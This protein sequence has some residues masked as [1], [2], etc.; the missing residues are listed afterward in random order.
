MSKKLSIRILLAAVIIYAPLIFCHP[1]CP[2]GPAGEGQII[3]HRGA[4]A[5]APENTLASFRKA[6]A[7]QPDY[8]E[9]DIHQTKD[10]VLV[11]I[12]DESIDRTSD[13]QGEISQLRF[14][15]LR[16]YDFGSWYNRS[17]ANEKIPT[18]DEVLS[19]IN[20][21]SKALIELKGD[22]GI[23]PTICDSLV[24][25]LHRHKGSA[26]CAVHSFNDYFLKRV[27][28]LDPSLELQKLVFTKLPFI[29]VYI[30]N[31]LRFGSLEKYS[32]FC[33]AISFQR[34]FINGCLVSR[35][36]EMGFKV[37]VWT[38]D[39]RAKIKALFEMGVDGVITD[40]PDRKTVGWK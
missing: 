17:F 21:Q 13:G 15:E 18:L 10:S 34:F 19:L 40:Y 36:H 12:H 6:L 9:F 4:A 24:K 29:P 16:K 3:A 26:W 30:D 32:S 31:G 33:S 39:D 22:K 23:Y 7:F 11:V 28:E 5:M 25:I 14:A 38:V 20:G 8:I 2:S 35:M 1:F 37:N 27:H